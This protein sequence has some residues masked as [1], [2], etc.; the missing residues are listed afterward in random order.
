MNFIGEYMAERCHLAEVKCEGCLHNCAGKEELAKKF[1][2]STDL[3]GILRAGGITH[4]NIANRIAEKMGL[5]AEERDR[6]VHK[7]HRGT[8]RPGGRNKKRISRDDKKEG[9]LPY[10]RMEVVVLD[11]LGGEIARYPCLQ[12]AAERIGISV[13][14]VSNRCRRMK[15]VQDEFSACGFTFRRAEEWDAMTEEERREDLKQGI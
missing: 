2:C 6:L 7:R 1:R 9:P 14:V 10:N 4:P 11:R 12:E 13:S 15:M 5:S 8:W 3:V